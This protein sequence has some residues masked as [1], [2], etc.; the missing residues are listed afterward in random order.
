MASLC[1]AFAFEVCIALVSL[2]YRSV[3]ISHDHHELAI[4]RLW[5]RA[6]YVH[7]DELE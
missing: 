4:C 5:Q 3:W 6:E 1:V 2:K 7:G